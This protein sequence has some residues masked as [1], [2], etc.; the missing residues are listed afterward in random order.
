MLRQLPFLIYSFISHESFLTNCNF[1]PSLCCLIFFNNDLS[2]YGFA[3]CFPLWLPSLFNWP[4]LSI[5][6]HFFPNRWYTLKES[7]LTMLIPSLLYN[8]SHWALLR[9]YDRMIKHEGR[10]LDPFC[11][12]LYFCLHLMYGVEK[13]DLNIPFNIFA[14]ICSRHLI[15]LAAVFP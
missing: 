4:R 7:V 1:V 3:Q 6:S 8:I 12:W 10:V 2:N 5:N 11:Y 15:S 14:F 9:V 13:G